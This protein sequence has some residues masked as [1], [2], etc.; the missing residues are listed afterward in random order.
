MDYLKSEQHYSDF[1]DLLTIKRCLNFSNLSTKTPGQKPKDPKGVAE[2]LATDIS[3]YYIKGEEYEKKSETINEWMRNDREKDE[4]L[5]SAQTPEN[6]RCSFCS[7]IMDMTLKELHHDNIRVMFWFECPVCK[8]RKAVFDNG[9]EYKHEPKPCPRCSYQVNEKLEKMGEVLTTYISCPNCEYKAK[10][11]W[12]WGKDQK[13]WD[14]KQREDAELLKKYRWQ[15]CLSEKEGHEYISLVTNLNALAEHLKERGQKETD[16]AYQKAKQLKKLNIVELEKLL[17]ELLEKEKYI[18]L[19]FDKPEME[20]FVIVSFTVQDADSTRAEY[21]STSKLK[22]LIKNTL[23][24]TNWRLMSEGTN[25]RLG[26]VS[27]RLKGY[28]REEDL[29]GLFRNTK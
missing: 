29:V 20:K 26:Y 4:R 11:V 1:Y 8:K 24:T 7:S 3:L 25:Y 27:G 6:I 22:K 28:E 12:D 14:E 9:E 19:S 2:N 17:S 18:K 16:P 10:E 23:E 15:F 21:D 13:E 5:K